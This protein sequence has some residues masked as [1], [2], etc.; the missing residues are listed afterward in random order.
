MGAHAVSLFVSVAFDGPFGAG[1][2]SGTDRIYLATE[3][4]IL[5]TSQ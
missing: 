3:L 2:S 4:D 5:G 1:K